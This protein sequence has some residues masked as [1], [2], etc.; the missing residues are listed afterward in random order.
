MELVARELAVT[1]NRLAAGRQIGRY[2]I[3]SRLGAGAMG[4]ETM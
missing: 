4:E 1:S 2:T 3:L